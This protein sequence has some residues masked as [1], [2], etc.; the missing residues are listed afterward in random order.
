MK[1]Q[2]QDAL[3]LKMIEKAAVSEHV[4]LITSLRH[5]LRYA[6]LYFLMWWLSSRAASGNVIV[7]IRVSSLIEA[8]DT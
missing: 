4:H 3:I 6:T 7:S 8:F 2:A 1:I 5:N